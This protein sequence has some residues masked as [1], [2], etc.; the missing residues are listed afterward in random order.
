MGSFKKLA[1]GH[2]VIFVLIIVIFVVIIEI[3]GG[4]LSFIVGDIYW[5]RLV[6][7][8]VQLL[9]VT[10]LLFLLWKFGWLRSAGITNPS[11]FRHWLLISPAITYLLIADM[12]A[13]FGD[14]SFQVEDPILAW[15]IVFKNVVDGGLWQEIAFRGIILFV[16]VRVW[17]QSRLGIFKS[18]ITSSLLFG[19]LH[20]LN[21]IGSVLDGGKPALMTIFQVIDTAFISGIYY[22]IFVLFSGSIWPVVVLHGLLNT[23]IN[24]KAVFIPDFT[25]TTS[26]WVKLSL[27]GIPVLVYS[28]CLLHKIKPCSV[29]SDIS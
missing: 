16:F 22:G 12:Y 23:L 24:I 28:L 11:R 2:P 3:A 15:V 13:V 19:V 17:G 1:T 10:C 7:G 14:F 4:I 6:H 9:G 21:L 27:F 25:E 5:S 29:V 8:L 18:I 20:L 26:M